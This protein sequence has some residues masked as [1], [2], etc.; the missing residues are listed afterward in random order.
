MDY[1]A[2]ILGKASRYEVV[3]KGCIPV[4]FILKGIY[5]STSVTGEFSFLQRMEKWKGNC[6][7]SKK[8][9]PINLISGNFALDEKV[10]VSSK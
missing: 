1:L 2:I 6:K 5:G 8:C 4:G 10:M 3:S 9:R 7:D